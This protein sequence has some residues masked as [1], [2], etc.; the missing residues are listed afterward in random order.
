MRANRAASPAFVAAGRRP[1]GANSMVIGVLRWRRQTGSCVCVAVTAMVFSV[2]VRFWLAFVAVGPLKVT[3]I[4]A[5]ISL[6][7]PVSSA[8]VMWLRD[9]PLTVN[10]AVGT[11]SAPGD[12]VDRAG[13]RQRVTGHDQLGGEGGAPVQHPAGAAGG[14]AQVQLARGDRAAGDVLG[15]VPVGE[16]PR[17]AREQQRRD[18]RGE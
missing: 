11:S 6:V 1:V 2:A 8:S 18:D 16:R 4:V 5:M 9:A 3:P 12:Q 14:R 13:L 7:A 17:S 15:V 10:V